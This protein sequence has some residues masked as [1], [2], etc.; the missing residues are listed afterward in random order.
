MPLAT[1]SARRRT[2]DGSG[3]GL[4]E[5]ADPL[6]DGLDGVGGEGGAGAALDG[7]VGFEAGLERLG[8][9][10]SA[11]DLVQGGA[12][13]VADED[14]D[15]LE[16]GELVGDGLEAGDEEVADGDVGLDG[17]AEHLAEAFEEGRIGG[18]V[19]DVHR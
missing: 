3:V 13:D 16:R 10:E 5:A 9:L 11:G 8:L 19:E 4:R 15:L 12:V 14:A 2:P 7:A 1:R 17:A 6:G 18:G